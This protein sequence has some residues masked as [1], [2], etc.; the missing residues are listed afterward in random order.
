MSGKRNNLLALSLLL[1]LCQAPEVAADKQHTFIDET[2][3]PT[4][5]VGR[6]AWKEI[7]VE[8]PPPPRDKDLIP[9]TVDDSENKDFTYAIDRRSLRVDEDRVVRYTL[10][11]ESRRGVRNYAFEGLRCHTKEYKVYAYGSSKGKMRA[12][13]E[14]KWKAIKDERFGRVHRD[15]HYYYMCEPNINRPLERDEIILALKGVKNTRAIDF[16]NP[17]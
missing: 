15:L 4:N 13:K 8:I 12:R 5:F 17:W 2:E 16:L 10:V 14:P 6:E 11:I 1:A 3:A 7:S 9:F